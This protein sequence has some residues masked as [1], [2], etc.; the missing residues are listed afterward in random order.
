MPCLLRI[1][2]FAASCLLAISAPIALAQSLNAVK[3]AFIN[4]QELAVTERRRE[5][6]ID[7]LRK[8]LQELTKRDW[9]V[10][11]DLFAFE[12]SA[13]E[14]STDEAHAKRIADAKL[15][16]AGRNRAEVERLLA[17]RPDVVYSPG[18]ASALFVA[19]MTKTVPIVF[20]CRCNPLK[21]GWNLVENPT[22]PERNLT[23]FTRYDLRYIRI[24][25]RDLQVANLFEAK[26]ALLKQSS[27]KSIHRVG[28]LTSEGWDEARWKYREKV[29]AAGLE[30][31][32]VLLTDATIGD[33]PRIVRELRIDA[34]I[35]QTENFL[36]KF[37]SRLIAAARESPVPIVFPWDEAGQGAW[38]HYGTKVDVEG[39]A[40][41]YVA[42]LVLGK[43]PA[44]LPVTFPDEYELGVNYATAK[45]HGWEF[46]REFSLRPQ[47]R[48][49]SN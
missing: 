21:G 47:R 27:T 11:V 1:V 3:V 13:F 2:L 24:E 23:G 16:I 32:E 44:D 45:K 30:P 38:F 29:R 48:F 25:S 35:M 43:K 22:R 28:L 42:Q 15:A 31:V 10:T 40:A 12:L 26:L 5:E 36:D 46:P 14:K 18:A 8:Q 17:S 37:S 49:D 20:A 7:K 33:L 39:L 9:S 34:G 19:D 41:E 6:L 4:N